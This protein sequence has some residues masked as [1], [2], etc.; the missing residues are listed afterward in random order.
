[1][2]ESLIFIDPKDKKKLKGFKKISAGLPD[3]QQKDK[4]RQ[5]ML[6]T[7][8]FFTSKQM[9]TAVQLQ[10]DLSS[11]PSGQEEGQYVQAG[12]ATSHRSH[13]LISLGDLSQR[14]TFN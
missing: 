11:G 1:M 2:P 6:C 12:P 4:S 14:T 13:R 9:K 3:A 7:R 5:G 10:W 8:S